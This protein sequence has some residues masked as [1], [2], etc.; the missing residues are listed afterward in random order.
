MIYVWKKQFSCNASIDNSIAIIRASISVID[1]CICIDK[2]KIC[3][4]LLLRE[5]T[6]VLCSIHC[7]IYNFRTINT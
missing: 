4:F 3:I 6:H 7:S 2:T 5:Y 1:K